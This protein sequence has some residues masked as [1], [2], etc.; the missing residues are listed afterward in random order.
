M[1]EDVGLFMVL[2][3][4]Y[5]ELTMC[6]TVGPKNV[7][8]Y[9]LQ[10]RR[11]FQVARHL[12]LPETEDEN[13]QREAQIRYNG[14][15]LKTHILHYVCSNLNSISNPHHLIKPDL[16]SGRTIPATERVLQENFSE[17][18]MMVM[19]IWRLKRSGQWNKVLNQTT[20]NK[21]TMEDNE[22]INS[23]PASVLNNDP[24]LLSSEESEEYSSRGSSEI[25]LVA[26]FV[27]E[28]DRALLEAAS[29]VRVLN[30]PNY[31][32]SD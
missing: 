27:E 13:L 28:L 26:N 22:Q 5:P 31:S 9:E 1:D 23:S 2:R 24:I 32:T 18:E 10:C 16:I 30:E 3:F 11:P 15:T 8:T 20:S 19:K 17:A 6:V 7:A 14:K 29:R 12:Y 4:C 25:C 21:L